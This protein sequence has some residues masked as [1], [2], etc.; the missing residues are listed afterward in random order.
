MRAALLCLLNFNGCDRYK[1]DPAGG[2]SVKAAGVS[3]LRVSLEK[4][5]KSRLNYQAYDK[6]GELNLNLH[7]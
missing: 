3:C 6:Y 5:I 2:F 1:C 7:A 4:K